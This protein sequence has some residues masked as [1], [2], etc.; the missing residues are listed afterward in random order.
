MTGGQLPNSKECNSTLMSETRRETLTPNPKECH[1]TLTSAIREDI[2]LPLY[3]FLYSLG[4]EY[5][6]KIAPGRLAN[7]TLKIQN[8]GL[9]INRKL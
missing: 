8:D 5:D 9:N 4:I 3:L 2:P 7:G 1:S 6:F